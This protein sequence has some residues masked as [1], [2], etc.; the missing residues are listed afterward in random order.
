[1]KFIDTIMELVNSD[2]F[3]NKLYAQVQKERRYT[4]RYSLMPGDPI[5]AEVLGLSANVV[6]VSY[7]GLALHIPGKRLPQAEEFKNADTITVTALNGVMTSQVVNV[8]DVRITEMGVFV[9]YEF[10]HQSPETLIFMKEII[11]PIHTGL[12]LFEQSADKGHTPYNTENWKTYKGEG[13]TNILAE[14]ASDGETLLRTLVTFIYEGTVYQLSFEGH[15]IQTAQI[16]LKDGFDFDTF[17]DAKKHKNPLPEVIL[18]CLSI[19]LGA[20]APIRNDLSELISTLLGWVS[21]DKKVA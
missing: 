21:K 8:R 13:P 18:A 10:R 15:K 9:A 17:A 5:T 2:N 3:S 19:F 7:G 14:F 4:E 20:E 1:M 6:D 11:E 16:N 12:S